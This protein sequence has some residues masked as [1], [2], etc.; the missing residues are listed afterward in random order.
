MPRKTNT[1]ITGRNGEELA[2]TYM[3]EKGFE[4]FKKNYRSGKAEIDLIMKKENLLVFAEVKLRK[5]TS[6]GMPEEAVSERKEELILEAA[7]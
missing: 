1:T 7:E 4:V 3:E 6:Y 5:K 2:A